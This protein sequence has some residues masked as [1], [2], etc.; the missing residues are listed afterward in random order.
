MVGDVSEVGGRPAA[1]RADLGGDLLG[2]RGG[3][4]ARTVA[5]G[6]P[7]VVDDDGRAEPGQFEGLG[8][9]EPRPAPVTIAD[10]PS[11]GRGS[12]ITI[13]GFLRCGRGSGSGGVQSSM[14]VRSD[15]PVRIWSSA[16]LTSSSRT[17]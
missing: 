10:S 11:S 12:D 13:L 5:A 7:V 14:Q 3:R 6:L 17:R 2:G 1:R 9:A 8:A 4:L 15:S 16:S